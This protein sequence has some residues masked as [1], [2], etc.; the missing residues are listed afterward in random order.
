MCIQTYYF[1]HSDYIWSKVN[2]LEYLLS[3]NCERS[4]PIDT[5]PMYQAILVFSIGF[6]NHGVEMSVKI[7]F[8]KYS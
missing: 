3:S 1:I 6:Q 4:A 2:D 8:T 7:C 5:A